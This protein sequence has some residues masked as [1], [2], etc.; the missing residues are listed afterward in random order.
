MTYRHVARPNEELHP[1]DSHL[2]KNE[3]KRARLTGQGCEAGGS[4]AVL[5]LS[6]PL[7][8]SADGQ[9]HREIKL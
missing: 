4:K 9:F 3:C 2:L 7:R 1:L 6:I 5:G 8:S